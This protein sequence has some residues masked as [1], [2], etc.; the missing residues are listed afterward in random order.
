MEVFVNNLSIL[1]N[2]RETFYQVYSK[3]R[4]T[5]CENLLTFQQLVQD[6][7]AKMNVL[8]DNRAKK[9]QQRFLS[10]E[11]LPYQG[12]T[13]YSLFSHSF[14]SWSLLSE[15][16]I[17]DQE[18]KNYADDFLTYHV[19][20]IFS[21]FRQESLRAFLLHKLSAKNG[22]SYPNIKRLDKLLDKI[23]KGIFKSQTEKDQKGSINPANSKE[24]VNNLQQQ[25]AVQQ[26][27]SNGGGTVPSS[28][29]D[30]VKVN[31]KTQL[32]QD[33]KWQQMNKELEILERERDRIQ[34]EFN[35]TRDTA[36]PFTDL[37]MLRQQNDRLINEL[38]KIANQIDQLRDQILLRQLEAMRFIQRSTLQAFEDAMASIR[39]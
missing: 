14:S 29:Q 34:K 36:T 10:N 9:Q 7:L 5:L 27:N 38:L 35:H 31:L 26:S 13:A 25:P 24:S 19:Q 23:Q 8:N 1:Q 37:V 6:F 39:K 11:N 17:T 4:A 20:K 16:L 2:Q 32:E 21:G 15:P 22:E 30:L 28:N 12:I 3:D 33:A 18:K